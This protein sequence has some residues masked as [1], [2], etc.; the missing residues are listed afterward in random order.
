[1][2]IDTREASVN[3]M[4]LSINL[5]DDSLNFLLKK[6]TFDKRK[7]LKKFLSANEKPLMIKY[8]EKISSN[9]YEKYNYHRLT[10]LFDKSP[11]HYFSDKRKSPQTPTIQLPS[12]SRIKLKHSQMTPSKLQTLDKLKTIIQAN[13][14]LHCL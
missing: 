12:L 11:Y 10:P 3:T 6:K 5:E 1:M 4:N 9:Y 7:I 8:K 14:Y 2:Q 13:K